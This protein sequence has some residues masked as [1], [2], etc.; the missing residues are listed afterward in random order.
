VAEVDESQYQ[1]DTADHN[2][3]IQ[4]PADGKQYRVV[5]GSWFLSSSGRKYLKVRP[6]LK[7]VV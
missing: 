1:E 3:N 2:G 4:I 6:D 7:R 5:R